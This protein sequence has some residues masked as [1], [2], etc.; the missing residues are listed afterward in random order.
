[1]AQLLKLTCVLATHTN[2]ST[3]AGER[4]CFWG[5]S[6]CVECMC[7]SQKIQTNSLAPS[8]TTTCAAREAGCTCQCGVHTM[9]PH[10]S[11]P[12]ST[13]RANEMRLTG[14][15]SGNPGACEN[16]GRLSFAS[17]A[18]ADPPQPWPVVLGLAPGN[19]RSGVATPPLRLEALPG[20]CLTHLPLAAFS[21]FVAASVERQPRQPQMGFLVPL[22]RDC[23][24]AL[25]FLMY[26]R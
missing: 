6:V 10:P 17:R 19:Q 15:K 24:G 12:E 4:F 9:W 20:N 1:M 23:C 18:V 11:Q 25:C 8:C 26:R 7:L 3:S 5:A 21:A 22:L 14:K 13:E 16:L 2:G